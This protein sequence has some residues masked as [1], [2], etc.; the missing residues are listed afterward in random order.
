MLKHC[1]SRESFKKK[2]TRS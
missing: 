2:I 1:C